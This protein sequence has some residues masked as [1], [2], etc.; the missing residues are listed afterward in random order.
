[1]AWLDYSFVGFLVVV[2]ATMFLIGELLVKSRGIFGVV[3]V[4]LITLYFAHHLDGL[5]NAWVVGAYLIGLTLI[6]IDGKLFGDGMV[7]ALGVG[8]MIVGLAI[9]APDLLYSVLVGFGV[10]IGGSGAFL[11]MKVFPRRELW[12]KM[13]FKDTLSS[14]EGYNSMNESY[15]DLVGKTGKTLS[16]F[17]PTGT[18]E[19]EGQ[20]YSAT[21]GASWLKANVDVEVKSVDGTRILIAEIP[22]ENK[23][24]V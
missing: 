20:P 24:E 11:F 4:V 19:I 21:T 13:T 23:E 6:L 8:L 17:R 2:L 5:G 15:R 22:K 9:P 12:T 14:E 1:M 10:L 3:G 16:D 18:V 7:S